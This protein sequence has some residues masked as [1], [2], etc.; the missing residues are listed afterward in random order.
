MIENL[1]ERIVDKMLKQLSEMCCDLN[2]NKEKAIE[3]IR[4]V[5]VNQIYNDPKYS[6][7][8]TLLNDAV[9]NYNVEMVKLLLENGADPNKVFADTECV[10]WDLHY[11]CGDNDE[12]GEKNLLMAHLLLEYG[13]DPMIE[14]DPQ[15]CNLLSEICFDIS[16]KDSDIR[17][18]EYQCRFLILLVAYGARTDLFQPKLLEN[19]DRKKARTYSLVFLKEKFENYYISEI[20]DE[21]QNVVA[22]V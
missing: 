2:F 4:Q 20:R 22:Y 6:F 3:L 14:P 21:N 9:E 18:W 1:V 16:E 19:F 10:L 15:D 12:E 8:T 17:T 11:M 13:A 7:Q 5:D